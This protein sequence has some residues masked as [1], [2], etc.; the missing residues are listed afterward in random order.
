MRTARRRPIKGYYPRAGR[1]HDCAS[2]SARFKQMWERSRSAD[3]PDVYGPHE[4]R[5]VLD[6]NEMREAVRDLVQRYRRLCLHYGKHA[7][8][9]TLRISRDE[10]DEQLHQLSTHFYFRDSKAVCEF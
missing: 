4:V 1:L 7:E 10:I 8:I 2:S 9:S 6:E 5:K 3:L